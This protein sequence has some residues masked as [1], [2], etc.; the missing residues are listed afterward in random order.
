MAE[1][2]WMG[3]WY[4]IS[5]SNTVTNA[6][7]DTE[8]KAGTSGQH[9]VWIN[10]QQVEVIKAAASLR[11]KFDQSTM[12]TDTR[13]V[14]YANVSGNKYSTGTYSHIMDNMIEKNAEALASIWI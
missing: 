6:D 10:Y 11:L 14:T 1:M 3:C 13:A 2:L 8:C 4:A 5:G 7:I 12:N 9:S